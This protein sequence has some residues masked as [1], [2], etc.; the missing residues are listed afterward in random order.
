M[1]VY[2]AVGV[3]IDPGG[4]IVVGDVVGVEEESCNDIEPRPVKKTCKDETEKR[5]EALLS[6]LSYPVY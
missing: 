1:V 3:E 2:C 4:G 6:V 5:E